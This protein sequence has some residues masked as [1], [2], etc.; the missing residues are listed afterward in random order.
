MAGGRSRRWANYLGVSKHELI[1]GGETLLGLGLIARI[2][3][4]HALR[5]GD[6]SWQRETNR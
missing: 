6:W 4:Q 2:G 5:G 3:K 1:V